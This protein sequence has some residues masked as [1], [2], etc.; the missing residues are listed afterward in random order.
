[1]PTATEAATDS[2]R[3]WDGWGTALKPAWEA[4]ILA[5]KPLGERNVAANVLAHGTGALNIDGCRIDSA[6]QWAGDDRASASTNGF[7]PGDADGWDGAW[8]KR[9]ASNPAGR[10]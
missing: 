8:T 9:S 10:V 1:M 7:G 6:E 3:E 2:A 4:I 5:R